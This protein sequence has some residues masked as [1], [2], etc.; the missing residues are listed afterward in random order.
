MWQVLSF[1]ADLPLLAKVFFDTFQALS[2]KD[3]CMVYCS[4]VETKKHTELGHCSKMPAVALGENSRERPGAFHEKGQSQ[5][6][7]WKHQCVIPIVLYQVNY[8]QKCW[9]MV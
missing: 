7:E 8:N 6:T 1:P 3:L 5:N 2:G 9:H 4:W